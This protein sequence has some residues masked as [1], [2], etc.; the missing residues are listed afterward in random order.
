M[1]S[2][3][4]VAEE[5]KAEQHMQHT[6]RNVHPFEMEEGRPVKPDPM[7][8]RTPD[9]KHCTKFACCWVFLSLVLILGILTAVFYPKKPH[10]SLYRSSLLEIDGFTGKCNEEGK[11]ECVAL[12]VAGLDL[13]NTPSISGIPSFLHSAM[14]KAWEILPVLDI[15]STS[16][17]IHPSLLP[18]PSHPHQSTTTNRRHGHLHHQDRQQEPLRT[19]L[20]KPRGGCARFRWHQNRHRH[21]A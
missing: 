8:Q 2:L 14:K 10:V 12:V 17:T 21:A 18:F 7:V 1:A 15:L 16:L 20:P 19:R 3:R 13:I 9:R 11:E 4:P 6:A 5:T